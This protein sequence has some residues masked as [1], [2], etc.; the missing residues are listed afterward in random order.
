MNEAELKKEL[1]ISDFRYLTKAKILQFASGLDKLDPD[2]A[3]KIIEQFPEFCNTMQS[4]VKEYK[5]SVQN[6]LE[7]ND[8]TTQK[9]IAA[10]DQILNTLSNMLDNE[11]L[12]FE[13]RQ[14]IIGQMKEVA[15]KIDAKDSENKFFLLK[16]AGVVTAALGAV[17]AVTVAALGGKTTVSTQNPNKSVGNG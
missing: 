12:S 5:E 11:C 10:Y 17:V 1:G 7:K 4:I 8:V 2:V 14:Y 9:S 15:E 13:E 6:I 3:K 16:M